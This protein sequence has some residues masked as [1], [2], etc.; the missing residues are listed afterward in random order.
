MRKI[1]RI[2]NQLKRAVQSVFYNSAEKRHSL[3]G[4]AKFWK[5]KRDFQIGF[6][7]KVGLQPHHYFLEI[8]CG[9]LRGGVPIIKYLENSHYYGIEARDNVLEE[10]K[11]ELAEANLITKQPVLVAAEDISSIELNQ[12]FDYVWAFSVLI[13]MTDNIL[14]DCL[15]FVSK[16]LK[17]DGFFY[18]NVNTN[19]TPDGAW[20]GFP[21]VHR[22][23]EFYTSE[24]SRYGLAFD[25]IG[26]LK[27]LGHI[28]KMEGDDN[29]MLK[30]YKIKS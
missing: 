11:K 17:A 2:A 1:K 21:V 3:V 23:I 10:G 7:K 15:A 14:R 22:S 27:D 4:P 25:I 9:T 5:I 12:K 29:I 16:N 30:I 18:A 28:T 19:T 20:Q 13:H 6:L 24:C 8:G 26:S